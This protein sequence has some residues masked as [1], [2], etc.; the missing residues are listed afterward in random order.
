LSFHALRV[1]FLCLGLY[2][3][4]GSGV[5]QAAD[6]LYGSGIPIPPICYPEQNPAPI[7]SGMGGSRMLANNCNRVL[8]H[9]VASLYSYDDPGCHHLGSALPG[10][11]QSLTVVEEVDSILKQKE[12]SNFHA[13]L[14]CEN[15]NQVLI[16]AFR[17]SVS[18]TRL[19]SLDPAAIED[20]IFVNA[21]L[22][23]GERPKQYQD[24]WKAAESIER[25]LSNGEFDGKCGSGR[26][27]ALVV[28]GHSKGGGQAQW[29]AYHVSLA[30]LVY[31]SDV[32]NPVIFSAWM[33]DNAVVEYLTRN[34]RRAQSL[35]GCFAGQI[36][37]HAS[38]YFTS[39]AITDV[40]MTNDK[41]LLSFLRVCHN[42]PHA[43]I[44]WV[45]NTLSC[46][47][48]G[49]SIETVVRE[50]KVCP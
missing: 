45:V 9:A 37:S 35:L 4:I 40:R 48:H 16:L 28:A 32:P 8:M 49:H 25:R 14:Y 11:A 36:N 3:G 44:N 5:V 41:W 43:P 39:G 12:S 17:G 46:S 21:A 23:F 34:L 31:N 1:S 47:A 26:P 15:I 33:Y 29:A 30:A 22:H 6:C 38:T 24:A 18:L 7:P 13:T 19:T 27:S 20:W 50:L 42:L 2:A 10:N